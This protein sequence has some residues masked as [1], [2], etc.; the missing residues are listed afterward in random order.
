MGVNFTKHE[1]DPNQAIMDKMRDFTLGQLRTIRSRVKSERVTEE[2]SEITHEESEKLISAKSHLLI[3]PKTTKTAG[4]N[5]GNRSG[6]AA[7]AGTASAGG[8]A[9]NGTSKGTAAAGNAPS[10]TRSLRL[11]RSGRVIRSTRPSKSA[12]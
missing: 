4:E 6:V 12:R 8:S 9:S 11:L 1:I 3:R 2:N 7:G 5:G 10:T